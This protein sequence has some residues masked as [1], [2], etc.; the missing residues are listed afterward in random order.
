MLERLTIFSLDR[1]NTTIALAVIVTVL[2]GLQ[3]PKIRID[4]NPENMLEADQEDRVAYDRIKEDFGIRDLIVLGIVDEAG[5]FWPEALEAVERIIEKIVA[6]QGVVI[7]DV[8][9][10]TTTDNVKSPS[11][12]LDIHPVMAEVP[13]TPDSIDTLRQD[14]ADNPFLHEKIASANGTALA[15]YVPI[16]SKDQSYRIASEI[17]AILDGAL[18]PGQTHHLAGLPVAEDTFGHE[19]FLEMAIVGPLTFL[20]VL[21]QK[22]R[23]VWYLGCRQKDARDLVGAF[24]LALG[25]L[26]TVR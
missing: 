18:L 23:I 21:I 13:R 14:I 19:M 24:K 12:F 5:I 17:E 6:V 11:G 1:P 22:T 4:T 16:E 15:I 2:L 3:F 25:Y 20:A 8:V 7:E 9:S 10:L 26:R